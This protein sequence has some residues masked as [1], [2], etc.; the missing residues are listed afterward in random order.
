MTASY[1]ANSIYGEKRPEVAQELQ[2]RMSESL[3]PLGFLV[4]E[5]LLREVILPEEIQAA[6]QEKLTAQQ[7]SERQEFINSQ[8]RQQL[9]FT[10]EKAQKEA[11]RQKIEAQA[12]AEAQRILSQGLTEQVLRLKAIEATQKLAESD[13]TKVIIIGGSEAGTPIILPGQ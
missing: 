11:E 9:E 3:S 5:T 2:K 7:E 1:S 6:I 10:I 4:E 13:N 8:E 12:T